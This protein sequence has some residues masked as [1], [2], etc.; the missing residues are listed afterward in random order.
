MNT[1][2]SAATNTRA[3]RV[4]LLVAGVAGQFAVMPVL[5]G[6]SSVVGLVAL[7]S[8]GVATV[9]MPLPKVAPGAKPGTFKVTMSGRQAFAL[10]VILGGAVLVL[11][12]VNS[13]DTNAKASA[14]ALLLVVVQVAHCLALSTRREAGLGCAIVVVM[15][16]VGAAFA[17]DV[18]LL[19]P[20]IVALAGI[21][22][23]AAL[24]HRGALI[25]SADVAATDGVAAIVR[26]CIAPVAL[27]T[28]VGLVV[29][30]LM[31][32]TGHLRA[33][34]RF[35]TAPADAGATTSTAQSA[36]QRATTNPGSGALDLRLRGSLSSSQVLEVPA[37]SPQYWQGAIFSDF[38]GRRWVATGPFT[39]WVAGPA[40]PNPEQIAPVDANEPVAGAQAHY[41]ARVLTTTPLDVVVGPQRPTTYT[42]PGAV[43][44]DGSGTAHLAGGPGPGST[45][46]VTST[47][48][49]NTSADALRAST[50]PDVAD[51]QFLALPADLPGRVTS[52]AASVAGNA[53]T[54]FDAVDAID[55]YLR[56][57]EKYN[58]NSP[59]PARGDDAV[60]DFLFVSH[61]GFCE[62]YASAGV[63]MLRSLG[64][65]ARL[66]TGY[67]NGDEKLV[68]GKRI[69]RGLD[70]HAWV[71]VFYPGVG[72]VNSDPTAGAEL[73][74][75]SRSLRQRFGDLLKRLWHDVPG[76]RWGAIAGLVVLVGAGVGL[77]LVGRR[78]LRRRRF[79]AGID[80]GRSNDGPVLAAYLRLDAVLHGVER[81]RAPSESFGEIARRLGGLVATAGEVA[82]AVACLERESYGVD[83]P[84]VSET[85]Y[86]VEVFDRLRVAAGSQP[87]AFAT[88][89]SS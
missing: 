39:R 18:T 51:P 49:V 24:L 26:A 60:D 48:P 12:R 86:A 59:L 1:S 79:L 73:V 70:L 56:T 10:A 47:R 7:L 63:V 62:Q 38:D 61:Q 71:Q 82:A 45:Y 33:K 57:H 64:I 5:S 52:L 29:F 32:N 89:P 6:L 74:A 80:R 85:A 65:P 22:V 66:V 76:G 34:T 72:W 4:S 9:R 69:Y 83:P 21:V 42:G 14:L 40:N 50:G 19:L 25:E 88:A 31:P 15:L 87:V 46:D 78:V 30:L 35:T 13:Y 37:D 84:S 41:V 75:S 54:R 3:A 2:E 20:M 53:Q 81:A 8:V 55:N 36:G 77:T 28:A 11:A 27:A 44:V 16:A 43:A 17:G 67:V 23:T 58:L 68:P